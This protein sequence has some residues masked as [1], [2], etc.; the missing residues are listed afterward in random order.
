[1][2]VDSE[3]KVL[4][5]KIRKYTWIE[6][7]KNEYISLKKRVNI[8]K[9]IKNEKPKRFNVSFCESDAGNKSI[10]D[11]SSAMKRPA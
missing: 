10:W 3:E 8:W 7:Y 6:I 1:M 4:E 5:S 2:S 11:K 9:S